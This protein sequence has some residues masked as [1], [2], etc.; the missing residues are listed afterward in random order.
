MLVLFWTSK[1]IKNVS[2]SKK[3]RANCKCC[4]VSSLIGPLHDA[5]IWYKIT[6]TGEQVAQLDFQNK[7]RCIVLEVP[8]CN[9]LTNI[10]SFVLCDRVVQR[11]YLLWRLGNQQKQCQMIVRLHVGLLAFWLAKNFGKSTKAVKQFHVGL[12]P[13]DW[14]RSLENQRC[15]MVVS[16]GL[17]IWLRRI[18][19]MRKTLTIAGQLIGLDSLKTIR[20]DAK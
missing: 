18:N 16:S 8:L 10:C 17:L 4:S 14:L 1:A 11:A 3:T 15:Q 5:V 6:Y 9:L 13:F 19:K 2:Y 12:L 20:K 7:G